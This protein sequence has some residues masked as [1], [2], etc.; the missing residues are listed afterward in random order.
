MHLATAL[1]SA[2]GDALTLNQLAQLQL[3]EADLDGALQT[4]RRLLSQHPSSYASRLAFARLLETCGEN[5][6]AS[7]Q[8]FRAMRDAQQGGRWLSAESTPPGMRPTV[9]HAAAVVKRHRRELCDRIVGPLAERFGSE[10]SAK[11]V[12]GVLDA[13]ARRLNKL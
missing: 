10:Q 1:D 11:F 5:E 9:A 8:Y 2:P 6:S 12:N 3:A 13:L 7:L 4:Y